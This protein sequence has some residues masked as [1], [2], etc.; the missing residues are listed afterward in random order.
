[1]KQ[2]QKISIRFFNDREV[3]KSSY[4]ENRLW[5]IHRWPDG[6]LL[7]TGSLEWWDNRPPNVPHDHVWLLSLDSNGCLAP[8]NCGVLSIP[9]EP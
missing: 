4:D 8:N 5:R 6:N 3:H 1:M 9:E 7:A 2:H